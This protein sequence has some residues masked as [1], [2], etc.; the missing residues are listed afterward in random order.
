MSI[1]GSTLTGAFT[2]HRPGRHA[3]RRPWKIMR[4][5]PLRGYVLDIDNCVYGFG[6]TP[7]DAI[8]SAI[9]PWEDSDACR[10]ISVWI[11]QDSDAGYVEV[12]MPPALLAT[13]AESPFEDPPAIDE[14][15]E[16]IQTL[17]G[18]RRIMRP[19]PV[20]GPES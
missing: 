5:D 11:R 6:S 19:A 18:Q 3:S 1:F 13:L 8:T 20:A 17:D 15:Y 9:G 4:S 12:I 2:T 16:V 7:L 10:V 14:R